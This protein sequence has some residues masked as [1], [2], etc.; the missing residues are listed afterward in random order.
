MFKKVNMVIVTYNPNVELLEKCIFSIIKDI[1]KVY[2]IDNQ[3]KELIID[4]DNSKIEFIK[5]KENMGIAFAQNIG[6]SKSIKDNVDYIL[7]SDQDTIYPNNYILDMIKIYNNSENIAAIAPLFND[8]NQGKKN[9]GF[10]KK[11]F[12]GN[13]FFYPNKG[14]YEVSQL[15]ASGK[16]I[17][18]KYLNDIG[19]MN[20]D[21]F[22]DW[23]DY[24]W[25]WKAISKGYKLIGNADKV[26]EHQLG[27]KAISMGS[28][29]IGLRSP[30]RH[31]YIT[32]NAFYLA[33][34]TKNLNKIHKIM[35]YLR[36]FRYI[37]GYPILAKPH[38]IHLKYVLLGFIHGIT[39]KLGKLNDLD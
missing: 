18:V 24:E 6:I 37:I 26:I 19:M 17:N 38:L 1:Y 3:S 7:L 10:M 11:T 2:I 16:I 9:E 15:I 35:L 34:N 28:K 31:Y 20:E 29:E 5:L 23:V 30:L 32:R 8:I 27:D 25:C 33:L 36:S 12:F 13:K 22:I 21:L 39:G 14:Q 4:I